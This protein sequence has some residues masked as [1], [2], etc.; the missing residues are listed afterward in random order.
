ME[1]LNKKDIVAILLELVTSD[2]RFYQGTYEEKA[3]Q[4]KK[5]YPNLIFDFCRYLQHLKLFEDNNKKYQ[6]FF[7]DKTLIP[8]LFTFD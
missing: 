5:N 8:V 3:S 2:H 4:F 1:L 6:E 7:D